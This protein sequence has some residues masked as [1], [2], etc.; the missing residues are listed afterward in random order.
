MLGGFGK[1]Q[2]FGDQR[3]DKEKHPLNLFS[4]PLK[5]ISSSSFTINYKVFTLI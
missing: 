2:M 3:K 4:F 1:N 5:N